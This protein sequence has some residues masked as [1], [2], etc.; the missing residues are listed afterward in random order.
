[1][2]GLVRLANRM[3]A[4]LLKPASSWSGIRMLS[5]STDQ[6]AC[7]VGSIASESARTSNASKLGVSACLLGGLSLTVPLLVPSPYALGLHEPYR[8]AQTDT[9]M[10]G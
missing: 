3:I 1:M 4:E 8:D 2:F 5:G 10:R 9:I 7:V 6:T